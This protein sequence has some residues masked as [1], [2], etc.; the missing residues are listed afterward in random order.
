MSS[1]ERQKTGWWRSRQNKAA[2]AAEATE[3]ALQEQEPERKREQEPGVQIDMNDDNAGAMKI[4]DGELVAIF[5]AAIA[6]TKGAGAPSFRVVSYRKTGQNAPVW[7]IR[8][9]ND[10]LSGKL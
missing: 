5:A 3:T 10:Y 7:N 8:G 9:R 6:Q 4:P 2:K 1:S